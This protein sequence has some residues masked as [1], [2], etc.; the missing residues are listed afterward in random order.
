MAKS[1]RKSNYILLWCL[2]LGIAVYVTH[3][4]TRQFSPP[5]TD[6]LVAGSQSAQA[7]HKSSSHPVAASNE[8]AA[9]KLEGGPHDH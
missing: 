3:R 9:I 1:N 6:G 7:H 5:P 4:A 8:S 2:V